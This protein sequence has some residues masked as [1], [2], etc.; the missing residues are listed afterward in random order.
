M[1]RPTLFRHRKF[2]TLAR[3]LNSKALAVGSLELLWDVANDSG[4]PLLGR[5]DDVEDIADWKGEEGALA[6]ALLE[7]GF[8]DATPD[9]LV[10]HDHDHHAPDYVR[11]RR[12][13]EEQR[14]ARGVSSPTERRPASA[15]RRPVDSTPLSPLPSPHTPHPK[16]RARAVET[17]SGEAFWETWREIFRKTQNGATVPDLTPRRS[18]ADHIVALVGAYP[19]GEYLAYMAELFLRVDTPDLR[20]K[21]RSIGMFRHWAPWCD[22]ELRKAGRAPKVVAA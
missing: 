20:G 7:A 19:D 4:D 1:A 6:A 22:A 11:K 3:L 2:R 16:E 9:G 18:D 13:R 10:V 14:K 12:A 21:P 15:E 8:L 17:G 5:A